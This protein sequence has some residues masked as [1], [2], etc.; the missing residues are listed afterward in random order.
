MTRF[1][2]MKRPP[3][4]PAEEWAKAAA[5]AKRRELEDLFAAQ[6]KAFRL[7]EPAR[8]FRFHPVR[9]WRTDF[10]WAEFMLLVEIEG[11]TPGGGRHQR[12]KGYEDDLDKYNEAQRLG[13]KL[14]RFSGRQVKR[15]EAIRRVADEL[16]RL[17]G[18]RA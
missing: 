2:R 7:P 3:L 1:P 16:S 11:L 6:V 13:F 14:L 17:S 8:E 12:M 18:V 9:L 4:S 5:A 15:G 10:A